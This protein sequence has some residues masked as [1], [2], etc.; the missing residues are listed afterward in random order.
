MYR[1]CGHTIFAFQ[2]QAAYVTNG[3][4][5]GKYSVADCYGSVIRRDVD[6]VLNTARQIY[7]DR[8]NR[9][10]EKSRS[11]VQIG[12]QCCL[13]VADGDTAGCRNRTAGVVEIVPTAGKAT[14]IGVNRSINI[15]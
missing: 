5:L 8:I 3:K 15:D 9:A 7:I 14:T 1:C 10:F 13:I 12:R 2:S 4:I 6:T 11:A